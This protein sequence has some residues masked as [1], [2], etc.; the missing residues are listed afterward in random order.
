MVIV[1]SQAWI[2]V[3]FCSTWKMTSQPAKVV[4]FVCSL[5]KIDRSTTFYHHAGWLPK[6]Y[7]GGKNSKAIFIICLWQLYTP[8]IIFIVKLRRMNGLQFAH[9]QS[10][11]ATELQ[12]MFPVE[13]LNM[14]VS[15]NGCTPNSWMAW[16]NRSE[17]DDL[18]DPYF[19]TPLHM[20]VFFF[21]FRCHYQILLIPLIYHM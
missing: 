4:F 9:R 18:G 21:F 6:T 11:L 2:W 20:V 8:Y 3:V 13:I 16:E 19:R 10:C 7:P 14:D 12:S 15:W 17:L 1:F 5:P